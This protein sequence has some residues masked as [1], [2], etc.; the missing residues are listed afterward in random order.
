MIPSLW[1]GARRALAFLIAAAFAGLAPVSAQVQ[2][3]GGNPMA[4]LSRDVSRVESLRQ[5]K[6][7]QR[8]YAQYAQY[9]LWNQV[10]GLFASD[11]R[12]T[13]DGQVKQ[14]QT[15]NGAQEI[16]R[17][18]R[19]RYGGGHEGLQAGDTRL[20][21]Y[22]A[23]LVTIAPN[24][25]EATGRWSV[26]SLIGGGGKAAI[27]GGIANVD[28]RL[29]DGRWKIVGVGFYP[30]YFGPYE[31]GWTNWGGGDLPIV[32][33]HFTP[34]DA[35]TPILPAAEPAVGNPTSTLA[36]LSARLRALGDE[37]TVRN[38]QSAFGYYADRKMWDDVVDLFASDGA[39][40][41]GEHVY[42]GKAAIRRWLET[43]M[44]PAG[45]RHGQLNDRPQFDVIVKVTGNE[46]STRGIE[47][48]L[49]GEAD[50]EQGWWEGAA[51]RNRFVREG[52]VWKI[53]ELRRYPLFKADYDKGWGADLS[54]RPATA[55]MP[56]F[57]QLNP[58]TDQ[59]VMPVGEAQF[60]VY[61]PLTAPIPHA[62]ARPD[63]TLEQAQAALRRSLAYD[64][65]ENVSAAYQAYLDDFKSDKFA[66]LLA[67]DGFKMSAFAG[68]YVGRERVAE[69][70]RRVW[71][72]EPV[73][74]TGIS[75]HWRIQP[76]ILV[77]DDGRSANMHVRLFQPRTGKDVGTAGGFYGAY[78]YSGMYHDQFVLEDGTWKMWNLSLDEPY[79]SNVQWKVGWARAKDPPPAAAG[80][81]APAPSVLV[82][83]DSDFKP[84]V[85]VA[86]LGAR[87]LHFRGGTGDPWQWPTIL[88]M[89]FEYK[90]P[91]SGRLPEHYQADC[92]PCLAR[93]DLRLDH[94][95]YQQ[96]PVWPQ[97][98]G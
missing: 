22:E 86:A 19:G 32:P 3:S 91:V 47:L 33:Y 34:E 60:A 25:R 70:G 2:V 97:K 7:L 31:T 44:G 55:P 35:G 87:E 59:Q 11:A 26:L 42:R 54:Q 17:F 74:R 85:P 14:G 75:F 36:R 69:A 21:V 20:I 64:S 65:I 79:M 29:L 88:P 49:L 24:G 71:G 4:E 46:A 30:Q 73:T 8:L 81:A 94:H 43:T 96:P 61:T 72:P 38:V 15:M 78:F 37:D 98:A 27:E 90:N 82:R 23:P 57:L 45:L 1:P 93:P 5:I 16:V 9:G 10:G 48:G 92:V 28:Y 12:F 51:F 50:R 80:A 52:G 89:W 53:R 84:D 58:V 6:D 63:M 40:Q 66:A 95:G 39:V 76:V 13:F 62:A 18:L 77:S 41:E 68:Y 56:R 67:R 83:A